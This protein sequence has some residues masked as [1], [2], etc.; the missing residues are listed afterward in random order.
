MFHSVLLYPGRW[1]LTWPASHKHRPTK[2]H[3]LFYIDKDIC[4]QCPNK[5]ITMCSVG[6]R[7]KNTELLKYYR[8]ARHTV[9]YNYT[10]SCNCKY[11]FTHLRLI[12]TSHWVLFSL[13]FAAFAGSWCV[14][15][16]AWQDGRLSLIEQDRSRC[17]LTD[18]IIFTVSEKNWQLTSHILGSEGI[19]KTQ[20]YDF[21]WN[22]CIFVTQFCQLRGLY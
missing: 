5:K 15:P 10:I 16:G 14:E 20:N 12:V 22:T 4:L 3:A 11:L 21:R 19:P 13:Q 2:Y 8:K 6:F 9:P 7:H 17:V 1:R 18:H